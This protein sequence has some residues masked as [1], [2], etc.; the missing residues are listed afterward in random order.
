[1]LVYVSE[2]YL[3]RGNRATKQQ[4]NIKDRETECFDDYFPLMLRRRRKCKLKHV[5]NWLNL[6]VD[7]HNG[8][9]GGEQS[10]SI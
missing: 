4:Y 10:P 1:M 3:E 2:M 9:R 7:F 6:S 5:I 8:E